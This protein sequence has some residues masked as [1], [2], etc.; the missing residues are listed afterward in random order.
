MYNNLIP[1]A[2]LHEAV[3]QLLAE[4]LTDVPNL[5]DRLTQ[6][7]IEQRAAA[8]HDHVDVAQLEAEREELRAQIAAILG[9]LK[10]AALADAQSELRRLGHRRNA[11]EA[12]LA[13][14]RNQHAADTRPVEQVVDEAVAVLAE[15]GRRLLTLT[16]EPLRELVNALIVDATVDMETKAVDLTVALP[17]WALHETPKG[18]GKRKNRT[19]GASEG[20]KAMCPVTPSRS[21]GGDWTHL[22]SSVCQGSVRISTSAANAALLATS[23]SGDQ[24]H[25]RGLRSFFENYKGSRVGLPKWRGTVP[26]RV[27]SVR[28]QEVR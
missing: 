24:R 20:N 5:R 14:A 12:M 8:L 22:S 13:Q 1:A 23:A 16:G 4:V 21:R 6:H 27:A 9:A 25:D 26:L 3:V 17:T 19:G 11:V 28:A 15:E 18:R 10:G 7:D 2:P